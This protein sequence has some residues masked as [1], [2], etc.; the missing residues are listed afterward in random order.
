MPLNKEIKPNLFDN[1]PLFAQLYGFKYFPPIQIIIRESSRGVVVN[2]WDCDIMINDSEL[3]PR[4]YVTL[5]LEPFGTVLSN[6]VW[7]KLFNK[8]GF[9]IK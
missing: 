8:D 4:N 3:Q 9:G 5:R 7:V 2:M 1:N 6:Q